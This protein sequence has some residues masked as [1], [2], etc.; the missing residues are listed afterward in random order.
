MQLGA[1][2][3]SFQAFEEIRV[4]EFVTW[5]IDDDDDRYLSRYLYNGICCM[6]TSIQTLFVGEV[7]QVGVR[8]AQRIVP[9]APS[10][11]LH[12]GAHPWRVAHIS[13]LTRRLVE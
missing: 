11:S 1:Y 9:L 5:I 6:V 7:R 12:P 8:S 3:E 4:V 2:L 13:R 10:G